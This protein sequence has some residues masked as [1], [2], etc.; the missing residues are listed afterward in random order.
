[1][2]IASKV[3][4]VGKRKE[5]RNV[6]QVREKITFFRQQKGSQGAPEVL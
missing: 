5:D 2:K 4:R 6:C 1:M 3:Q